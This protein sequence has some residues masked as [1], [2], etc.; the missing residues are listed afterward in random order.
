MACFRAYS[1]TLFIVLNMML[2]L[3][4]NGLKRSLKLADLGFLGTL[5]AIKISCSSCWSLWSMVVASE[6][7]DGDAGLSLERPTIIMC[8]GEDMSRLTSSNNYL[9]L[10]GTPF[11]PSL[12]GDVVHHVRWKYHQEDAP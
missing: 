3:V 8:C 12:F 1:D 4:L 9:R 6:L 10:L 11:S 2:E 5:K 7:E